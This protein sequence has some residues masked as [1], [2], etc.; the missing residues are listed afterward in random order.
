MFIFKTNL[1]KCVCK[2]LI[3]IKIC[4]FVTSNVRLTDELVF[5]LMHSSSIPKLLKLIPTVFI[6]FFLLFFVQ[7]QYLHILLQAP[8]LLFHHLTLHTVNDIHIKIYSFF[9]MYLFQ[10]IVCHNHIFFVYMD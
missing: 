1:S 6:K 9:C 2:Y 3:Y 10:T 5:S 8:D 7:D 4:I